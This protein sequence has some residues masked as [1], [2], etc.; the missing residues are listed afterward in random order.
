VPCIA[1]YE[2]AAQDDASLTQAALAIGFPLM[3]KAAAGGGGRGMRLVHEAEQLAGAIRSARS[4]AQ[5]AFGS[6]ELIIEKAVI[7]P[8]HIEVQIFADSH[9]NVVYLGERD[10]SLQRR[11]QKV[12][13]EAPSPFVDAAL[14][15]RMG[16]AAVAVARACNYVGAG[17]VEFLVDAARDFYFLEMNTRLQVEHPVTELVTGQ[18]LVEWQLRIACGEPLPLTQTQI[19]LTGHA[20]EVRLYA[21]DPAQNF[22]PQ[23]GR[24]QR[25]RPA[26]SA[27]VRID[28]GIVEGQNIGS[29]FDPMLAK[30]I[31]HGSTRE[32]A[33]RRLLLAVQD[34]VLLGFNDN[35]HFLAN[36]LQH[37][38]FIEGGTT[39][40]FIDSV[41]RD[42]PSRQKAAMDTESLAVAALLWH[43]PP[44]WHSSAGGARQLK[45]RIGEQDFALQVESAVSNRQT[46]I[47]YSG[48]AQLAVRAI[49]RDEST[50]R[51]EID[52]VQR[53][54]QF[55]FDG[56]VLFLESPAGNLAVE[57]VTFEST[58]S[59]AAASRQIVAIMDGIIV[60][61]DCAVGQHVQRGQ[62]LAV[63]EAMKMQHELKA[64][65]DG[66]IRHIHVAMGSQVKL[67]QSLIEIDDGR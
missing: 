40:A 36:M 20:I 63:M 35:R 60:S 46:L 28:S 54:R 47:V 23:T 8:R 24:I 44:A 15:Q 42:D 2:G 61:L 37:P 18:D 11:H 33:R 4:E 39:T 52:G 51:Y 30:I 41:F 17:T 50:L 26:S 10:C 12:L 48:K 3:L 57:N 13:E 25:W 5:N 66:T 34:S 58:R 29:Q 49:A 9:G 64:G 55:A 62:T 56:K 16:D 19:R 67:R 38:V 7:N 14:R 21:E 43:K 22:L 45:L 59:Q 6:G 53:T 1:G 65:T 32:E 27:G 31:A